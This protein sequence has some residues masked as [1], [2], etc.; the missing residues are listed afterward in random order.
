M[1]SRRDCVRALAGGALGVAG[2]TAIGQV[3]SPEPLP[4]T[5]SPFGRVQLA[6]DNRAAFCFLPLTIAERLGYFAAEGL[7]MQ[8]RDIGEPGQALQAL[9]TGSVQALSGSYSQSLLLH[10]RGQSFPSIV[11]QGRAPQVVLGV[12]RKTLGNY[13]QL[14]DLRGRKVAITAPGSASQRLVQ[15]LLASAR[16]DRDDVQYLPMD[17]ASSVLAAFRNGRVDAVCYTDPVITQL[18]QDGALRVVADTRTVRGNAEAFGGPMPAGCLMVSSAYLASHVAECQAM[19]NAMVHALKWLQTAGPSDIIRT[20]PEAFF[21]GDRALYLSAFSR[22]REAWSPDGL[23]PDTGPATV[24]RTLERVGVAGLP[25][26]TELAQTFTN[27][28]AQ[29]AKARFRA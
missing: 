27:A 9:V 6:V 29:K 16:M 19:V 11:L 13:R 22:A 15:V 3:R 5:R 14:R 17:S 4:V 7:D 8:V 1:W 26:R 12:S 25:R 2:P 18:E 21:L 20:V 28:L 10:A 24:H 23:M